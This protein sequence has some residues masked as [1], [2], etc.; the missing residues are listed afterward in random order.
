MRN[1]KKTT[2]TLCG[3]RSGF[4]KL[5]PRQPTLWVSFILHIQY[6]TEALSLQVLNCAGCSESLSLGR[7]G[8]LP[9]GQEIAPWGGWHRVAMT[10]RGFIAKHNNSTPLSVALRAPAPPEGSLLHPSLSALSLPAPAPHSATNPRPPKRIAPKSK[11]HIRC[12]FKE[13]N[14]SFPDHSRF[15]MPKPGKLLLHFT[16]TVGADLVILAFLLIVQTVLFQQE[17]IDTHNQH[18]RLIVI[19]RRRVFGNNNP[20]EEISRQH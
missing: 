11:H 12:S 7:Q 19:R 9:V 2:P 14:I 5:F 20:L 10:E 1:K 4:L 3:V 15:T 13:A 17:V 16:P 18:T 6:T 8:E